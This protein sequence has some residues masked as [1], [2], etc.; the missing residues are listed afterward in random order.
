MVGRTCALLSIVKRQAGDV[1]GQRR[2]QKGP[3]GTV[4]INYCRSVT[5]KRQ[6]FL[7]RAGVYQGSA[8]VFF[9]S[10]TSAFFSSIYT[11]THRFRLWGRNTVPGSEASP[12]NARTRH[13]IVLYLNRINPVL[14]RRG[15]MTKQLPE[16][17]NQRAESFLYQARQKPDLSLARQAAQ[18]GRAPIKACSIMCGAVLHP[19][20][21][22]SR[23]TL[24]E[25]YPRYRGLFEVQN[26]G[27]SV[28]EIAGFSAISDSRSVAL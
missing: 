8:S 16:V 20:M 6:L 18:D 21:V 13:S 24:Q 19:Q 10:V 22:R 17:T 25:M 3:P 5:W 11:H 28:R 23:T 4:S 15:T 9:P 2:T 26:R 1:A 27:S 12:K 14:R 7:Q